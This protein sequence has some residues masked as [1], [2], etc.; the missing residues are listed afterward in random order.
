MS[1]KILFIFVIKEQK[2]YEQSALRE[3]LVRGGPFR[4]P[5]GLLKKQ[6][7]FLRV[8]R[9]NDSLGEKPNAL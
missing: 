2:E 3:K 1:L 5:G 4:K 6:N 9:V 8:F 7:G